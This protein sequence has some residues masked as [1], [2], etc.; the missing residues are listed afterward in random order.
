MAIRE[1]L[2]GG[3]QRFK[4]FWSSLLRWQQI[5][6]IGA[7]VVVLGGVLAIALLA[8]RTNYEPLF[9]DLEPVDQEK[10][11]T[12]LREGGIPYRTD[13]TAGAIL[14]P[15]ANVYEARIALASQGVPTNGAVGWERFSKSRMG[16]TS[17]QERN[18]IL[19][20]L[21]GELTR[22]IRSMAAVESARV[23]I[24]VPESRLFL[25]QQ[26]PS[27]AAVLL[28]LKPGPPFG[29]S[30]AKAVVHLVASSVPGLTPDNVT[31]VDSDGAVRFE[32]YLDDTLTVNGTDI[33][34]KNRQFEKQFEKDQQDK[35]K[36]L[37]RVQ[38]PK[39]AVAVTAE[40]DFDKKELATMTFIPLEG[41]NFG[42]YQSDQLT[43]ESYEGPAGIQGGV[44]GTTTNIPGYMVNTGE[45][46]G[47]AT[48][49]RSDT[50]RN[51]QNS[52]RESRETMSIGTVKNFSATVFVDYRDGTMPRARLDALRT[53]VATAINLKEERGDR[54]TVMA[55]PF[56]TSLEDA[57]AARL[58]AE[59]QTRVMIG[60]GSFAVLLAAIVGAMAYWLRRRRYLAA[61]EAARME[62]SEQT[63]S[64]RELLENP[65]LMTSQGELSILE[66]QLR[67]YAMN[68][69]EELANLIK[70]WVVDDV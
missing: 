59:R 13:S 20:A 33:V 62:E 35:I 66:E 26:Q 5:S 58:A 42:A 51:Y 2:T 38:Y 21:E 25:E 46:G 40:L 32:D 23:N 29:P 22:T 55:I 34:L 54:L 3:G 41:K 48:Y 68:N 47:N 65:D 31:L 70:N 12:Y 53:A 30:Q 28:T 24:V 14:V 36:M 7:A 9:A 60:A 27:T 17:V 4:D 49:E 6:L 39:V 45:G 16:D 61:L 15:T 18:Q 50:T 63:P 56:D 67:N 69:P 52:T 43:E 44:P 11:L 1:T 8:G 10:V 19:R 37:L 57:L 64:L